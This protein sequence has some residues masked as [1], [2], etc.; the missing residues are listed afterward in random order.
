MM[1]T[2]TMMMMITVTLI[3][4]ITTTTTMMMMVVMMITTT[5]TMMI[6]VTLTE[7]MTTTTTMMMM[8]K[9]I[10][11]TTTTKITTTTLTI[12]TTTATTTTTTTLT[13][14]P[15]PP[16]FPHP[17][18]YLPTPCCRLDSE[19]S[20]AP[21]TTGRTRR[22]PKR[23][24]SNASWAMRAEMATSVRNGSCSSEGHHGNLNLYSPF[25]GG[26]ETAGVGGGGKGTPTHDAKAN[27]A[28]LGCRLSTIA[29]E[30]CAVAKLTAT[31]P[32]SLPVP[33]APEADGPSLAIEN[34]GYML[35]TRCQPQD[36]IN[37][38]MS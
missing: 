3:E 5:T 4:V 35:M 11:T 26:A 33:P 21:E 15:F 7:T 13:H 38:G 29:E 6:T 12:T 31:F 1:M 14:P 30:P 25:P 37:C 2:T 22:P 10:T 19:S 23:S 27:P 34:A 18:C 16:A 28:L 8:V 36:Y 9:M 24:E 32:M 17:P 20:L